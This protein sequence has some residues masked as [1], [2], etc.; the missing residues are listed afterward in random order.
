MNYIFHLY[1]HL[2]L[3]NITVREDVNNS[4]AAVFPVI[5]Y[6]LCVYYILRTQ[7]CVYYNIICV[8][9]YIVYASE[10]NCTLNAP[11]R[12]PIL[13]DF[14]ANFGH[15]IIS[16]SSLLD[17]TFFRDGGRML[18]N[19]LANSFIH[20]YSIHFI[21]RILLCVTLIFIN[22]FLRYLIIL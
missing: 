6:V 19:E 15:L 12:I 9:S 10:C 2:L 3:T 5:I 8:N 17:Q 18:Y 1:I 22:N 21:F 4:A 7:D 20:I 16:V 11:T 14:N 13:T